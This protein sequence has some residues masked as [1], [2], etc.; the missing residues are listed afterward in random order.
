M[1]SAQGSSPVNFEDCW[2]I[3]VLKFNVWS[4]HMYLKSSLSCFCDE[5]LHLYV[6]YLSMGRTHCMSNANSFK[7]KLA[8]VPLVD[9]AWDLRI[10]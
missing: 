7:T 4:V 9:S 8:F 6:H 2:T 3:Q 10:L 1:L 5:K